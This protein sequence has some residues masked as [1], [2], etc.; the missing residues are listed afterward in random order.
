MPTDGSRIEQWSRA[1]SILKHYVD[2]T[3]RFY[4][5]TTVVG[6]D[7]IPNRGTHIFAP[8][9]QNALMDALAVLSVRNWQ[10]IFLARADI[11]RKP[12]ANRILTFMKI[13][14]VYRIRDGYEN[15]Q[16][17][18]SIFQKTQDVIRN[19]NGLVILPE[20]NHA[21]A[22]L[23]RPLKKGIARIAFQAAEASPNELDIMIIPVGL[24]YKDYVDVG[25]TLL[26]R[27]GPPIAL[28]RLMPI[29]R[30]NPAKAYNALLKL[31]ERG[32]KS[33]MIHVEDQ[34][35]YD[36]YMVILNSI[37]PPILKENGV[38]LT[39]LNV[40]DAQQAFL[41]N[42]KKYR[43][44][45]PDDYLLLMAQA[46]EYRNL[47]LKHGLTLNAFKPCDIRAIGATLV[48]MVLI[49]LSVPF[50]VYSL[51]NNLFPLVIPLVASRYIKDQQFHSSVRFVLGILLFP[52]FHF[53]QV[54]LFAVI[55]GNFIFTIIYA[56]SL[57]LSVLVFFKLK[58]VV[59]NFCCR[60]KE[61]AFKLMN[62]TSSQRLQTLS[63]A[64]VK[65]TESIL[66]GKFEEES[67]TYLGR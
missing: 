39:H 48:Q 20:G 52:L 32:M 63:N 17:N 47:K 30:S 36:A 51:V 35:Y 28:R 8:N 3:F 44:K 16:L 25:S 9:H 41:K 29:Y 59:L 42:I 5:P 38:N 23:L 26:V 11:F 33:E 2:F 37:I 15:L 4:F 46:L 14:P 19:R 55:S 13:L 34:V 53:I 50:L 21:G 12:L 58:R 60:V 31:L 54:L 61:N 10:P 7:S 62:R 40:F 56:A 67:A 64:L 43:D 45:L 65:N 1:Y 57:P 24:D 27:F 18:D 49:I 22:K 6:L 66:Y